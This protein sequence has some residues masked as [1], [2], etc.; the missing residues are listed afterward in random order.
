MNISEPAT[1]HKPGT[2]YLP[3]FF[4]MRRVAQYGEALALMSY[5]GDFPSTSHFF[6]ICVLF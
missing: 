1:R 3:D 4:V 2:L 5:V 6:R